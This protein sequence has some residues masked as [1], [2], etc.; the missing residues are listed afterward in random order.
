[1]FLNQSA[2]SNSKQGADNIY[3]AVITIVDRFKL[4]E[5]A[6]YQPLMKDFVRKWDGVF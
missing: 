1:M 6:I 2:D 3:L 5:M 4:K